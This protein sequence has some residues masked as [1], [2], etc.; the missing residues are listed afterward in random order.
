[1]PYAFICFHIFSC[2]QT[3]PHHWAAASVQ[4]H[5]LRKSTQCLGSFTQQG[6]AGHQLTEMA[7]FAHPLGLIGCSCLFQSVLFF[8]N[9]GTGLSRSCC[10]K[11][12]PEEPSESSSYQFN[13][14]FSPTKDCHFE[15]YRPNCILP[16]GT[17][18][19]SSRLSLRKPMAHFIT[20]KLRS[21]MALGFRRPVRG[22]RMIHNGT[23]R[24]P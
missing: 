19:K 10:S 17:S 11:K 18:S 13:H 3:Q 20:P 2:H 22:L 9:D 6:D 24:I 7:T 16:I 23:V 4:L 8:F 12:Q 14:H 5:E 1:M 15:G 21:N